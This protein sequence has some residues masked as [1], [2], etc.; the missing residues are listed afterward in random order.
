MTSLPQ[1][2][3]RNPVLVNLLMGTILV[4]GAYAAMT[5]VRELFP[6]FRPNQV[7]ITTVYPGA[8]P[9]EIEK[10]IT[11]KIEE[12]IKDVDGV[13]RVLS[14]VSEGYST[15]LVEFESGFN[16]IDRAVNDIKAAID[17]IPAED[18]PEDA[19]ETQVVKFEP[20]LP[21]ISVAL[22]GNL[23]DRELKTLGEEL[24]DELLRLP[25]VTNVVLVGTRKDEISVEVKPAKLVEYG[26]SFLDVANAIGASNMDLPG[27]QLRT[28]GTTVAVRTLGER[29]DAADMLDIVLR[30]DP[31]GG[32]VKV[33]DVAEVIDG[34]EDVDV[35]G[36]FGG[37]P[38]V[39]AVVYKTPD[40]D[41]IAIAAQV[42]ALV[43]GKT[44]QPL[45]RSWKDRLIARFKPEDRIAN[46][47]D[48]A[49]SMPFPTNVSMALHSDLSRFVE[50]RLDLLERNGMW[51]LILVT[52][53][54]LVFLHWRVALWVMMGLVLAVA[55]SLLA[56]KLL[57]QT[58]NLMTMFGLIVVLGLL[59]D[60]AIIVAEHVYSKIEQGVEPK[61]A[62][63]TGA[64]EVT[65]PVVCAIVTTICAFIP[66]MFIKGRMGDFMGVLPVIVC[67]ALSVS[68]FEAL[69]ILPSHLAH[70]L[71]PAQDAAA[72]SARQGSLLRPFFGVVAALRSV[73]EKFVQK[74]MRAGY[75]AFLRFA[76][77]QRYVTM[78][79]LVAIL[80]I[81]VG[82][83][84]GEH[85]PFVFIQHMDSETVVANVT[86]EVGTPLEETIGAA[87]VVER[88]ALA[89]PE[90]RT[91]Y[92]LLG[93]HAAN[94]G[95]V[96][97]PR[98]H[99]AQ[100]FVEISEAEKRNRTSEDIVAAM[101][102]A[103]S[104][105]PGVRKLKYSSI[106]GGPA[107][108]P[109]HLEISGENVADLVAVADSVKR[110]LET[111]KGVSDIV[112]DYDAGRREVQIELLESARALGLTTESLAL[113]V[114]AAFYGLEA[115]KI[116]RGRED[117]RIMVRYP[118]EHRRRIYD[119]ESMRIATPN[120][121]LV[122]FT[123]VARL[124]EATGFA[125]I[126]RKNQRRT[127]TINA[128]VNEDISNSEQ[129]LASLSKSFPK[130]LAA[131]PG[132]KMEF[133]GQKLETKKSFSSLKTDF[134]AAL[135]MIYAILAG[136]F[137]SYIEPI[138][139]MIVIPFGLIG[140]VVGH[141]VMGYPLTFLSMIGLVALT[142][143][144]VND[145]MILVA[146]INRL[147]EDGADRFEAVIE[148]A[149]DRL[150]P[151]LLTSATTVLGVAP[152]LLERSFQAKF[153][154]PMGISISAGL[155]FSTVLTLIAVPSLYLIVHDVRG[156]I[157]LAAPTGAGAARRQQAVAEAQMSASGR[158]DG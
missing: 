53:S 91:V 35:T 21:V 118:L 80:I 10:G 14:T 77:R 136:L 60:D 133:A 28:T 67:V 83:V 131:H 93:M 116:Q 106:Q 74:R 54:L 148:A 65:W 154:I 147:V 158:R 94:D 2:S 81:V 84:A 59:V 157:G 62:A 79:A 57:G 75:E 5:L 26:L 25:D 107:G 142:G 128:D 42:R 1:F 64:E 73:Q 139:V 100:V 120:G 55:G 78:A 153:L 69:T 112:D 123:E 37:Q 113:Q 12:Q 124:T 38:S 96:T 89:Q 146:F 134:L 137:K 13:D 155:I 92:T 151:I 22:F 44:R 130:Y 11:L 63:V 110:D 117:V 88:I 143:I 68:L 49:F 3:V 125:S 23:S 32:T 46:I 52:L 99:L 50:G 58:L 18:F 45:Q 140:A 17:T 29:E 15:I 6:E 141:Y 70:G 138:I 119:I 16:E 150:R 39:D 24:K 82:A 121:A 4:G 72:A 98:S 109:I 149:K 40:Q 7:M 56:M 47:Y 111:Y 71:R 144:V 135:L 102:D 152:L 48:Q 66:L 95:T 145:S 43:M 36:R 129:V 30:S 114:R 31:D 156:L 9:A 87:S 51:G 8:T 97:S 19:L 115:R 27:G 127:I 122:P 76:L 103:T 85:V 34:F 126:K 108:A 132:L 61:L 104:S 105:I 90:T 20:R 33:G 41:A 101:R 86:M